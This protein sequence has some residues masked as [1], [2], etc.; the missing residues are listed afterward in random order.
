[1]DDVVSFVTLGERRVRVRDVVATGYIDSVVALVG[2]AEVEVS[3]EVAAD[4][5]VD[6]DVGVDGDTTPT[7]GVGIETPDAL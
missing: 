1:M 7:F 3:V 5:A 4:A 2:D 6:V